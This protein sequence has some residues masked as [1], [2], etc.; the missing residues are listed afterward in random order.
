MTRLAIPFA[1]LLLFAAPASAQKSAAIDLWTQN[2]VAFGIFVPNED[3]AAR[4]PGPPR[5]EMRPAVYS[6][7]GAEKLAANPLYDFL[8][9]NLEP[10]FDAAA[11][12]A[13]AE[14]LRTGKGTSRK[15]LIVRIPTPGAD[16]LPAVKARIK[17]AFELGADGVTVPH[18]RSV[19]EAKQVIEFFR[20]TGA[21]IWTPANPKGEK[22]AM[23]MLE[24]PE[25]VA[26]ANEIADLRGY[27]IL[28]C[29][30]GSL[31]QALGGNREAAEAGT[32]NVLAETK[33]AKLVNML[34]TSTRDVEQRVKEGFL[35][36]IA[37]G[38]GAD[39]AIKAGRS[40]A[41]R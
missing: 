17:E 13:I 25:A 24:D 2:K 5:G 28:A 23:L 29:G 1:L 3:P 40:A 18:I 22:L 37:Q 39:D 38:Q 36:L 27:S 12:K 9:L 32:Q 4:P 33:R 8:F 11:I 6:R 15:T 14:G 26:H 7:G 20:D 10:R 30:I 34:T 16:G 35:A 19:D 21:Q 41:G 31:A